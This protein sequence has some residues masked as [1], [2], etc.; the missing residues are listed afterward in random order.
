MRRPDLVIGSDRL[1]LYEF[2][3]RRKEVLSGHNKQLIKLMIG[4]T[5]AHGLIVQIPTQFSH[6][7]GDSVSDAEKALGA[8]D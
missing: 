7:F 5:I 1:E 4:I 8:T 6:F 3:A 2:L